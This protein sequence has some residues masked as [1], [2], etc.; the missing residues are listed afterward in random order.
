MARIDSYL[1]FAV[2]QGASD[3]HA[4]TGA[5]PSFRIKGRMTAASG[6]SAGP[7]SAADV[8][9]LIE[10]I[11]PEQQRSEYEETGDADFAYEIK[12]LGRF[13]VN[14][15]MDRRG[16]GAVLRHTSY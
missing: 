2:E 9:E 8:R 12:K 11:I 1:R 6:G 15:F 5:R 7:F 16:P 10:E 4:S 14:V 3:F 13:R